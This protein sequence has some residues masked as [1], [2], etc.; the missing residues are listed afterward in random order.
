MLPD[1]NTG[2]SVQ[3]HVLEQMSSAWEDK[4]LT[5]FDAMI[6]NRSLTK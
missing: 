1:F 6:N 3:E 2:V 5:F 4:V